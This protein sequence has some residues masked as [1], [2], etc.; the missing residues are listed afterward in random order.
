LLKVLEVATDTVLSI[1]Q[2]HSG[3]ITSLLWT[4]D[5]RQIISGG[6]DTCLCIWNFYLGGAMN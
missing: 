1:G 5:E 3:S 4:N 6:A 2:A